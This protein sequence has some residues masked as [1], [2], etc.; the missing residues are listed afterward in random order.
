MVNNYSQWSNSIPGLSYIRNSLI[1]PLLFAT[2]QI[3]ES[4]MPETSAAASALFV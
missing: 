2:E 1:K 4:Y 3:I